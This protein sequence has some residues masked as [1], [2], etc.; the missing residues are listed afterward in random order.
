[1]QYNEDIP[2]FRRYRYMGF[3]PLHDWVLI[4][5]SSPEEKTSSGII[6]PDAARSKSTEGIVVAVGPGKFELEKG[7]KEKKF[8]PTVLKPGQH[9]IFI[10]YMAKEIALN[11]EEITLIQEDNILG[12]FESSGA[13][14][15]KEPYHIQVK[16]EHPPM[17]QAVKEMAGAKE[18]VK[19]KTK[20]KITTKKKK[21]PAVKVELATTF[22]KSAMTGKAAK[23][24]KADAKSKT[25]KSSAQGKEKKMK[26]TAKKAAP[27][28]AAAKKVVKKTVA[29]KAAP[30]KVAAKKTVKKTAVKKVVAKKAA[31]KKAAPKKAAAKKSVKKTAAKKK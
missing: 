2:F 31:P 7:K 6:I 13:L 23:Q 15:V 10:D 20:K 1:L 3:R 30:M 4:K 18:K 9:I 5:R 26:K 21:G 17:V 8:V 12:V 27:K 28:K 24:V 16:K 11:G 29:K 22:R 25:K 19:V 14:A